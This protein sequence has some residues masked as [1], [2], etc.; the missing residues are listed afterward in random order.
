M[1]PKERSQLIS[2]AKISSDSV[3]ALS[4]VA[5]D[6]RIPKQFR[7][8]A[9]SFLGDLGNKAYSRVPCPISLLTCKEQDFRKQVLKTL[10]RITSEDFG[11]DPED[12]DK[13][14]KELVE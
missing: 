13:W 8:Q 1:Q 5:K 10:R 12:W 3:T 6:T 4:N 2:S 14:W 11:E 7:M 9:I